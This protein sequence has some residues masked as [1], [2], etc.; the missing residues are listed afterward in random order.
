VDS[1]DKALELLAKI[2]AGEI[3]FE[4]AAAEHSSCP[5]GR[6]GGSLG[7]FG[8]GQ[9]V[10]EFDEACFAMEVG[11]ISEP[12]KTQFGYHIIRLDSKKDA[13]PMHFGDVREGITRQLT[14]DKQRAAYQ[15][16]LNQLKILYPV[17]RM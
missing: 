1:E 9:M 7:E 6:N 10:P 15:S 11:A 3:A 4:D 14:M 13:E 17:D 16:K 5:S 2:R 8:H 12:V